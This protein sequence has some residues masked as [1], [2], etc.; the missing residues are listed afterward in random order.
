MKPNVMDLGISGGFSILQFGFYSGLCKRFIKHFLRN[1]HHEH[2]CYFVVLLLLMFLYRGQITETKYRNMGDP[3]QAIA[4]IQAW[5]NHV[6]D[7]C[8]G[9]RG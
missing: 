3:L 7:H 6:F 2:N 4:T 9:G 5:Q 1:N 8:H